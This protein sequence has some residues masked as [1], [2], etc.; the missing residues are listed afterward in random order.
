MGD[1]SSLLFLVASRN[2]FKGPIPVGFCRLVELIVLDLS[3]NS[4]SDK[5]PHCFNLSSLIYLSLH[6]N[7][8]SGPLPGALYRSSSLV[9]LDI[10]DNKLSG[11]IPRWINLLPNLRFLLLNRNNFV[12]SIP[13]QLCQLH[14]ISILDLSFNN[15]SGLIPSRLTDI[16]FGRR[17]AHDQTFKNFSVENNNLSGRAPD[18]KAQFAT[19][20]ARSYEGNPFLC[21]LPLQENCGRSTG[22]VSNPNPGDPGETDDLFK[23]SFFQTFVPSCVVA[24]LGVAAF[25]YFNSTCRMIFQFIEAKLLSSR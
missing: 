10:G 21:G 11:E 7:E 9:T 23:D 22:A 24:F 3:W 25:I 2:L 8:L 12:G 17:K 19:F 16:P 1:F 5:I 6:K 15:I 13:F 14:N 20:D 18:R 4:L